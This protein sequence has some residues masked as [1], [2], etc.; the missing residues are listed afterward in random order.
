[1]GNFERMNKKV[2]QD[3][4]KNKVRRE[5]LAKFFYDIA[6]LVFGAMVLVGGVSVITNDSD[7]SYIVLLILGL[8]FTT[9]LALVGNNVLKY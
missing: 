1:M 5:N 7:S 9:L 2:Q 3:H 4:E 6:K 8:F